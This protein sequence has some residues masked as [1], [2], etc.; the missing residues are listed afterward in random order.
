M[1]RSEMRKEIDKIEKRYRISFS[2]CLM[3][4]SWLTRLGRCVGSVTV[5]PFV[6]LLL[7]SPV[8]S[9]RESLEVLYHEM[10]HAFFRKYDVELPKEFARRTRWKDG[11]LRRGLRLVQTARLPSFVSGYARTTCEEDFCETFSCY[12]RNRKTEGRMRYEGE[13]FVVAR[14]T[15]LHRKLCFVAKTLKEGGP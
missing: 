4:S 12:L 13:E 9:R 6:K 3:V 14:G 2:V 1:K 10:G 15:R 7:I 8:L 11:Y 5:L